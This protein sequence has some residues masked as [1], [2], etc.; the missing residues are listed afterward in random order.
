[1]HL[2]PFEIVADEQVLD[3][4]DDLLA[5]ETVRPVPPSLEVQRPSAGLIDVG[6]EVGLFVQHS[7]GGLDPFKVL[8]STLDPNALDGLSHQPPLVFC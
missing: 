3:D 6:K 4:G 8:P 7:V 1:M 5:P 2:A